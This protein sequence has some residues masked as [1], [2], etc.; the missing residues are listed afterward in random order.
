MPRPIIPSIEEGIGRKL[1]RILA[2]GVRLQIKGGRGGVE[3]LDEGQ[4]RE[5]GRASH[6]RSEAVE[7][8]Y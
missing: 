1:Q 4:S 5:S 8:S 2:G 3:S 6:A 7:L